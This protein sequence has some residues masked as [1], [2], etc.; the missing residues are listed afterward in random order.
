ML[1]KVEIAVTFVLSRYWNISIANPG[2]YSCH[3]Y[4]LTSSKILTAV[5]KN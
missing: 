3:Y 4:S 5:V 2:I 1:L